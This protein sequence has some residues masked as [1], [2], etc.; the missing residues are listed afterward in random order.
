MT[1]SYKPA[2]IIPAAIMRMPLSAKA[3]LLWGQ[4]KFHRNRAT[5]QC[6]PRYKVLAEELGLCLNSVRRGMA[7]LR[8]AGLVTATKHVRASSYVLY[9][10]PQ[11]LPHAENLAVDI[12]EEPVQSAQFEHS[13]VSNVEHSRVSNFEHSKEPNERNLTKGTYGGGEV[14]GYTGEQGALDFSPPPP[15]SSENENQNATPTRK[16]P[17][18][19]TNRDFVAVQASMHSLAE[20]LRV[21]PPDDALVRQVIAAA[22]TATGEQI[23]ATLAALNRSGKLRNMRSWGLVPFLVGEYCRMAC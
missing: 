7:E 23:H 15:L 1:P 6:N 13:R 8:R 17:A 2:L 16:P 21:R 20:V 14:Y 18:S 12:E 4:L 10:I 9:E 5:G 3:K 19:E 22:P 11:D